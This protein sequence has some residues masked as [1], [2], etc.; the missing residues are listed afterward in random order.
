MARQKFYMANNGP[1]IDLNR[2]LA[3]LLS[4]IYFFI[5][6]EILKRGWLPVKLIDYINNKKIAENITAF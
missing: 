4:L 1:D 3:G 6:W 5:S 2:M